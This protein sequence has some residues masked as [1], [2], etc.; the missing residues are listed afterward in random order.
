MK[1][2]ELMLLFANNDITRGQRAFECLYQR[3]KGP[4]YRFIRKS[5]N[6]EA[7]CDELF[8]DLWLRIIN[9]KQ[10]YNPEFK[11]TTWAY[12]IANRLLIDWFRKQGKNIEDQSELEA[13][14]HS[15]KQPDNE[16]ERKRLAKQLHQAITTLPEAQRRTFVLKHESDM[17]LSEVAVATEQ[18][19]ERIKSQYRYAVNKL[20]S[21]LEAWQ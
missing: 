13:E 5:C 11:F 18:P 9:N 12:T 21:A 14:D 3:H 1:D 4:L 10:S 15:F 16:L 19:L 7:Q 2:E 8:Q 6:N 17:S 20:K